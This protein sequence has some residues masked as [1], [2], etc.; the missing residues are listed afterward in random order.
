MIVLG[1]EQEVRRDDG[2]AHRDDQQDQKH[3]QHEAIDVI[4]LCKTKQ[5]QTG[6]FMLANW[7]KSR[8]PNRAACLAGG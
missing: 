3:Q 7:V 2:D 4:H 5:L 8:T 6:V 1:V